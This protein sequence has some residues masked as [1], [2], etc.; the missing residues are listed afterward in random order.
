MAPSRLS[1][2]P[3]VEGCNKMTCPRCKTFICYVCRSE[4][5]ASIG[6]QHFCQTPHCQHKSCHK[7]P[8]YS[9]A[10]EDD[11]RASREAG[12]KTVQTL[13][14]NAIDGNFAEK[15]EH[16]LGREE[17][18]ITSNSARTVVDARPDIMARN[19]GYVGV[20]HVHNLPRFDALRALEELNRRGRR[21]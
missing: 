10:E 6:Y 12:L 15:L 21:R 16:L 1:L 13:S 17:G 2:D 7:C 19:A 3:K 4:I 20:G 18:K 8:L 14:D 9:N 11:A 5:P